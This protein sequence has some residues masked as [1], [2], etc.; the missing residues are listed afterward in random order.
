MT[1]WSWRHLYFEHSQLVVFYP[2]VFFR[3]SRLLYSI[4]SYEKNEQVW[5]ADLSKRQTATVIFQHIFHI[6]LSIYPIYQGNTQ[7]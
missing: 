5:Q 1:S 2:P 7:H 6:H 3:N 4:V